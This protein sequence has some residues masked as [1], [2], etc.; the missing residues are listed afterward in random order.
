[1]AETARDNLTAPPLTR[2]LNVAESFSSLVRHWVPSLAALVAALIALMVTLTFQNATSDAPVLVKSTPGQLVLWMVE[3]SKL[4]EPVALLGQTAKQWAATLG[5]SELDTITVLNAA[6]GGLVIFGGLIVTAVLVGVVGLLRSA[7]WSRSAL[8]AG[9]LGFDALLFTVPPLDGDS[10]LP[11]V[12]VG[13]FALLAVL[14]V[15]PGKVSK[16]MGFMVILSALLMMWEASKGFGTLTNYK[17]TLPRP[18]WN[19]STYPTLDD[20]LKA[21]NAGD[22]KIIIADQSKVDKLVA[23]FP[24]SKTNPKTLP[25]PDLRYLN[26]LTRDSTFIGLP[27]APA[28]PTRLSAVV[29]ADVA[30]SIKS[31]DD[32]AGQTLGAVKEDFADSKYLA[33]PRNLVLVDLGITNDLNMPHLQ[34]I[35]EA[36]LQ[37]ARRNGPVLL[38]RILSEN[39][40]FTWSEAVSGFVSGALLGFLLGAL[41]AHSRLLERGLLPYVV[42]SQTIP[43]LAIAPMVV[44]WLGAGPSAVAVIAAYL[45]FFPVTINTLRGLTSP[46]PVALELMQSYAASKWTTMWKLRFPAALPYIFTALKVSATASVVGAIIGEL[47]S[48]I[49][50]GLGR[51]ILDF[52]QYYT[53]DPAKLWAAIFIAALVGIASFIVVSFIEYLVLRGKV[54]EA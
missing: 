47:P 39:A 46:Q 40:L 33:L 5:Q 6:R 3:Q 14:L 17:I 52:N 50:N 32:V 12:L 38:M 27:I 15:A 19:Y 43:I 13:I 49:R 24:D 44:I 18:G 37:P 21:L 2:S 30:D 29:R 26:T 22:V 54:Q 31:L 9:L 51:S 1:M 7:S 42:A 28:L 20:A 35:A 25:Y 53:S 16:L 4:D 48:G 34:N 45:T 8:L 36:L 10:T 41:F 11:L 23:S